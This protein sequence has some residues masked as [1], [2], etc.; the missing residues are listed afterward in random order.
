VENGFEEID[1]TAD[2]GIRAF[3][4]DLPEAF[5]NTARGMF[6]LIT[7]LESIRAAVIKE[8]YIKA[9]DREVLLVEW[10]NEMIYYFDTEGLLFSRFEITSLTETEIKSKCYG[11]KADRCRHELKRGIKSTTY[12]MLKIDKKDEQYRVQV[13]FDI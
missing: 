1:H 7:D 11:E 13:L 8:L 4:T 2:I 3:G 10:L 12:H 5:A 6:S 9:P